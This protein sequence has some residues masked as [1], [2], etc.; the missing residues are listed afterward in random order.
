[1]PKV[2]LG[3]GWIFNVQGQ[4]AWTIMINHRMGPL[5]STLNVL[6]RLSDAQFSPHE[7]KNTL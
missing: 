5:K 3:K 4:I 2:T 1:M 7:K 6:L